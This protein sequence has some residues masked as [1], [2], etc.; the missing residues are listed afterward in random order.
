MLEKNKCSGLTGK[1]GDILVSH[2]LLFAR[3][4]IFSCKYK[5]SK[6][7]ASIV[8]YI[9]HVKGNFITEKKNLFLKERRKFLKKSGK[10]IYP[11]KHLV[12]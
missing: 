7:Y 12:E 2:C 1:E 11:E 4:Y 8:E 6:P 5:N 10:N 3:F 9:Y